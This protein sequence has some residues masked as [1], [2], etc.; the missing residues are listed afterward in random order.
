M[1]ETFKDRLLSEQKELN[2]KINK[3]DQFINSSNKYH[4]LNPVQRALLPVQLAAMVAY[5]TCLVHRISFL[6]EL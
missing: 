6:D 1:E 2:V 5:N 4:D 3:L